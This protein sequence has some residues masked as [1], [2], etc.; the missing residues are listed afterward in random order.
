MTTALQSKILKLELQ[1]N[2]V[3][4]LH[5]TPTL[6]MYRHA[7]MPDINSPIHTSCIACMQKKEVLQSSHT[8]KI[9]TVLRVLQSIAR[10]FTNMDNKK[11]ICYLS[12][13][14]NQK[15]K[16]VVGTIGLIV[17]SMEPKNPKGQ[18]L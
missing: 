15:L 10:G 17:Q 9:T 13:Y 16:V 3:H 11:L 12:L 14:R 5:P 18:L 1:V 8:T 6:Y 4:G 2:I 7:G